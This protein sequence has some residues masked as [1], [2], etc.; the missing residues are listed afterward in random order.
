[1]APEKSYK[2][3]KT[4]IHSVFILIFFKWNEYFIAELRN[5]NETTTNKND[6]DMKTIYNSEPWRW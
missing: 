3:S 2:Q 5:E 1:M 6:D 4:R